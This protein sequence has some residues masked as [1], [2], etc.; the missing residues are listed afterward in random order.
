MTV[1]GMLSPENELRLK[2][3]HKDCN[4]AP[5]R[6]MIVR[7]LLRDTSRLAYGITRQPPVRVAIHARTI[8]PPEGEG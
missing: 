4:G 1:E 3:Y 8:L 5:K 7:D 2:V 6:E